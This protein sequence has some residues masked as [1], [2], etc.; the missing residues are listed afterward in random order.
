M[1]RTLRMPSRIASGLLYANGKFYIHTWA[2]VW[3][4]EWVAVDPTLNQFPADASHLRF[5]I[6]GSARQAELMQLV[7]NL[8]IK[9]LEAK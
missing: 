2:E 8:K 3:L 4:G 9:V 5:V 7:G 6:G 1:L